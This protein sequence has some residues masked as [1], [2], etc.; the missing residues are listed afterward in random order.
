[1]SAVYFSHEGSRGVATW[2]V[3]ED[4]TGP[5]E[6]CCAVHLGAYGDA[7]VRSCFEALVGAV[8]DFHRR[9]HVVVAA[10]PISLLAGLPCAACPSPQ[11]EELRHLLGQ[12]ASV[13][14][15]AT[16]PNGLPISCCRV[17]ALGAFVQSDAPQPTARR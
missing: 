13:E 8:A 5:G 16:T 1:M 3:I 11:A 15:I 9:T 14:Q 4:D 12:G 17:R 6:F 7:Q 10:A 2:H